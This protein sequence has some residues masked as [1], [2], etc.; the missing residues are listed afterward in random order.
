MM[1]ETSQVITQLRGELTT[2]HQRV[3]RLTVQVQT[4]EAVLTALQDALAA[5]EAEMAVQSATLAELQNTLEEQAVVESELRQEL[6]ERDAAQQAL[7][8]ERQQY[9]SLFELAPDG[10]LLTNTRGAIQDA[11]PAAARLLGMSAAHLLGKPLAGFVAREDAP[12]FHTFL[13]AL[14][15]MLPPG[16][17]WIGRF[18]PPRCH[19]FLGELTV[20][21]RHEDC[22]QVGWYHWL[23]RDITARTAL[24]EALQQA[25]AEQQRLEREAQRVE[26]FALLGRLAAGV[27]HEIRNPLAAIFLHVD[28]LE[29]ELRTPSAERI[30]ETS[31]SLTEIKTQLAHL[32]NLVQDYLSLVRVQTVERTPQDLGAMVQEWVQEWWHLA[33]AG[34]VTLQL[35]GLEQVDEV[36]INAPALRRAVLN[37]V[38][39]ALEAMS[40]GW[41]LALVGQRT[42]TAVHLQI[43]DT[44]N[45]IPAEVLPQIFDPLF[46]TKP[47]GTGLGLYIVQEIVAAHGGQVT[48]ESCKG[49]GTTFTITLPIATDDSTTT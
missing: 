16:E 23:L 35:D 28:L 47:G 6:A 17:T 31:E 9:Q 24:I 46:T 5:R 45:G 26:H 18:R 48:V 4:Q 13:H 27:S 34:G 43:R 11:N 3:V 10:Y 30:E 39:N 8:A 7:T 42:A 12:R 38:Q 49:Q 20:A 37:L 21:T 32:D 41:T 25:L 33:T 29:E 22:L 44:G 14:Q 2:L 40:Q 1:E 36:A 19:P 15:T